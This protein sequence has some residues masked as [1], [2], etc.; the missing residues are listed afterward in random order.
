M[1]GYSKVGSCKF[2][3]MEH[4]AHEIAYKGG[5][6]PQP[7]NSFLVHSAL[8]QKLGKKANDERQKVLWT[9]YKEKML[10]RQRLV[11]H[12]GVDEAI[13][14]VRELNAKEI[15][16]EETHVCSLWPEGTVFTYGTYVRYV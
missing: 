7:F 5:A 13:E 1:I 12:Y 14:V 2:D 10:P 8:F 6:S 16:P 3:S 11:R 9:E 4:E 15:P